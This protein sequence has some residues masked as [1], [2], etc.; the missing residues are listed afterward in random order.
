MRR[1]DLR[2]AISRFLF[3]FSLPLS[4]RGHDALTLPKNFFSS[5]LGEVI[6]INGEDCFLIGQ[7]VAV[8]PLRRCGSCPQCSRGKYALCDNLSIFGVYEDG[9][10]GG[11]YIVPVETLH[12]LPRGLSDDVAALAEPLAVAIHALRLANCDVDSLFHL[13]TNSF[14]SA[15]NAVERA[16]GE[17]G[18]SSICIVGAGS[19]GLLVLTV[20]VLLQVPKIAIIARHGF[21]QAAARSIAKKLGDRGGDIVVLAAADDFSAPPPEVVFETVGGNTSTLVESVTLVRKGGSVVLLGVFDD[22]APRPHPLDIMGK[23]ITVIGSMCYDHSGKHSDFAISIRLLEIMG[24][25][26]HKAIVTHVYDLKDAEVAFAVAIDKQRYESIKVQIRMN[27]P[28][29]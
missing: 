5:T 8:E 19:V 21:Q 13:P 10:F 6:D 1:Y 17:E 25:I 4:N 14:E 7:R 15:T 29:L 18:P 22:A 23:G 11:D 12:R 9:G 16:K 3:A 27:K 24:N 20:A 2:W 26:L 28:I